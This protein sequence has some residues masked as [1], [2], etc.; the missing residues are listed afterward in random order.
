[1]N[2]YDKRVH[3]RISHRA[4]ADYRYKYDDPQSY[5]HAFVCTQVRVHTVM[6][7]CMPHCYNKTRDRETE[8]LDVPS[9]SQVPP[10]RWKYGIHVASRASVSLNRTGLLNNIARNRNADASIRGKAADAL[11]S[12]PPPEEDWVAPGNSGMTPDVD[13]V[14]ADDDACEELEE[15]PEFDVVD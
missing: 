1:L 4:D 12:P 14:E 15:V 7:Q 6:I 9:D 2:V 13:V 3:I 11:G 5:I 10:S 8:P